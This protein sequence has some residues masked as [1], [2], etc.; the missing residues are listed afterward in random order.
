MLGIF[1]IL[2]LSLGCAPE[3]HDDQFGENTDTADTGFL[4][5]TPTSKGL[6]SWSD[7]DSKAI[8]KGKSSTVTFAPGRKGPHKMEFINSSAYAQSGTMTPSWR[9]G[10]GAWSSWG[11]YSTTWNYQTI[12]LNSGSTKINYKM[13]F[14]A[15]NN[16]DT[17]YWRFCTD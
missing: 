3:A 6:C 5:A 14:K 12:I 8:S 10:T 13:V 1:S 7:W 4:S 2:L 9:S 15:T 16:S 17:F 11:P